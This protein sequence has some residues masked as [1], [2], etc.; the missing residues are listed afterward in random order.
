MELLR[1]NIISIKKVERFFLLVAFMTLGV[2]LYYNFFVDP[3]RFAGTHL[4][5]VNDLRGYRFKFSSSLLV[6]LYFYSLFKV[7]KEKSYGYLIVHLITIAYFLFFY[8]SRTYLVVIGITTIIFFLRNI[9]SKFLIKWFAITVVGLALFTFFLQQVRPDII[10]KYEELYTNALM[11]IVGENTD[12][13]STN[14]RI[15]EFDLVI[16]YIK[17]RPILG[18]GMVGRMWNE[19]WRGL[20][21]YFYPSDIGIFG[22]LFVFG[23]FGTAIFYYLFFYGF[24]LSKKI[25]YDNLFMLTIQYTFLFLFFLMFFTS[26]N[27]KNASVIYFLLAIIYYFR[28]YHENKIVMSTKIRID[29]DQLK[30]KVAE[31]V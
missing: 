15:K 27:I 11:I 22:N 18:N 16:D 17:E 20:F 6:M 31:P 21:G 23:I 12:E 26:F 13:Y 19:G 30:Q 25:K 1:K 7:V 10:Q 4:V 14:A 24:S 2:F 8:Q 5:A 29:P 9:S 3:S 28:Y